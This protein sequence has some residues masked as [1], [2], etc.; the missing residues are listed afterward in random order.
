M[1][2]RR[3]TLNQLLT[4]TE[5]YRGETQHS[6]LPLSKTDWQENEYEFNRLFIGPQALPA[7]PYASVY[8]E[9]EPQLMGKSTGEIRQLLHGLGLAVSL[10]N[11]V[12][13]DHVSY[14]IEL[15]LLLAK[16]APQ[17]PVY[18]ETLAWLVGEHMRHWLPLFTT[19]V[20]Q[21]ARTPSLSAVSRIL[22]L[23]FVDAQRRIA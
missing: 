15:S 18:A 11:R 6:A 10:E 3:E 12:P 4:L 19:R 22:S 5:T 16:L 7:P 13:D 17:Q 20:E 1:S 2:P 21:H 8:L 23:W 9:A 14:E